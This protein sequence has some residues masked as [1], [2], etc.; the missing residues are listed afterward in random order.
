MARHNS[1]PSHVAYVQL[2]LV[3][4]N[5]FMARGIHHRLGTTM[6]ILSNERPER[7]GRTDCISPISC[8]LQSRR[9]G[10]C[11]TV[12]LSDLYK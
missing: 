8:F 12:T 7:H 5:N 10:D 6:Y 1:T 2:V 4:A 3:I 9:F 11:L